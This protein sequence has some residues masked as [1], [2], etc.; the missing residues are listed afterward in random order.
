MLG[1]QSNIVHCRLHPPENIDQNKTVN[2]VF[3]AHP[4]AAFLLVN[5]KMGN[6]QEFTIF[7]HNLRGQFLQPSPDCGA[8]PTQYRAPVLTL[9]NVDEDVIHLTCV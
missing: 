7:L 8:A 6:P 5:T 2:L 1:T 3:S 4:N 9:R